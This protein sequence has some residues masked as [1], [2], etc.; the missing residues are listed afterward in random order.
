[1][2]TPALQLIN[3]GCYSTP[4]LDLDSAVFVVSLFFQATGLS[5]QKIAVLKSSYNEAA[6]RL[7]IGWKS[8]GHRR[9]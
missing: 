3:W 2:A 6:M 5:R 4:F 1:M 7:K 9:R 8:D